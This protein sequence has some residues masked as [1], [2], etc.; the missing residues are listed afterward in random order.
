MDGRG[1]AGI[2]INGEGPEKDAVC[3][4]GSILFGLL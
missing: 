2:K 4:A 3:E 1:W